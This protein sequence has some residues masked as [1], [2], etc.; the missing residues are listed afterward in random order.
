[1]C[2]NRLLSKNDFKKVLMEDIGFLFVHPTIAL[3]CI[4]LEN[5]AQSENDLFLFKCFVAFF[6]AE[7]AI[8]FR[9][10]FRKEKYKDKYLDGLGDFDHGR[11]DYFIGF[12][13]LF[14]SAVMMFNSAFFVGSPSPRAFW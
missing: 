9:C 2:K 10:L 6:L 3:I 14:L 11:D 13:P 5:T 8:L 7:L 4:S 1:M 12:F